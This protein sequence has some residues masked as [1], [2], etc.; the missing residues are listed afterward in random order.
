MTLI[1]V[2]PVSVRKYGDDAQRIFTQIRAR[3]QQLS[4]D[5][6]SVNYEGV[7]AADFK[8]RTGQIAAEF[9]MNLVKDMG[10]MA[11]AVRVATT[12]IAGSLGGAPITIQVN[13]QAITPHDVT[14]ADTSQVDTSALEALKGTISA[15]LRRRHRAARRAPVGAGRHHLGGHGQDRRRP[16]GRVPHQRSE[17]EGQR[18]AEGAERRDRPPDRVDAAGRRVAVLTSTD[19]PA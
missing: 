18:D 1:K 13:G 17:R 11:E 14:A 5:V 12:N 2:D 9:S 3:L 16:R 10:S 8:K 6:V 15:A 4:D 7:N 19:R